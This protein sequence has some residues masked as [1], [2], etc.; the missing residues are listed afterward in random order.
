MFEVLHKSVPYPWDKKGQSMRQAL[1][2]ARNRKVD[3]VEVVKI[4]TSA[5]TGVRSCILSY[6]RF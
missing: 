1:K 6:I 4:H 2:D 5:N 3:F